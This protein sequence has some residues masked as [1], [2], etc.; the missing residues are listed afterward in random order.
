MSMTV[1]IRI[2]AV[3]SASYGG[4]RSHDLR[5]G[6]KLKYVDSN[7]TKLNT[8]DDVPTISEVHK[9]NRAAKD[10]ARTAAAALYE[11]A[12]ASGDE[13]RIKEAKDAKNACRQRYDESGVVAYRG[14]ITWGREAQKILKKLSREEIT[15]MVRDSVT[16]VAGVLNTEEFGV[17]VHFDESAPHGHFSLL[18]TNMAG[19]KLHPKK[20]D[21]RQIQSQAAKPFEHLGIRRGKSKNMW[22][23]EGAD[24]SKYIHQ[25][26][27]E[28]HGNL[29]LELAAARQAVVEAK[30]ELDR[31]RAEAAVADLGKMITEDEA[32]K[33]QDRV[34][35]L[36]AEVGRLEALGGEWGAYIASQEAYSDTLAEDIKAKEVEFAKL[37]GL[38]D[39][40]LEATKLEGESHE[41]VSGVQ[42]QIRHR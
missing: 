1:S 8:G 22:I 36:K 26:V 13:N 25:S 37:T 28:L 4:Q 12:V 31:I 23:E 41:V 5:L 40:S 2:G 6:K 33:L 39:D 30:A 9:L 7:R 16:A 24:T 34:S 3:R 19:K 38:V 21:C 27:A 18:A 11:A 29:P 35:G 32:E 14:I 10:A 20:A 15:S 17:R 42:R